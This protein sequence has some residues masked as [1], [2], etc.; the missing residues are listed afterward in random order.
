MSDKSEIVEIF[1]AFVYGCEIHLNEYLTYKKC[2][3]TIRGTFLRPPVL[4]N[5]LKHYKVGLDAYGN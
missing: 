3:P 2:V 1:N 4:F 5:F